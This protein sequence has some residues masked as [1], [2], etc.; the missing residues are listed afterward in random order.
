MIINFLVPYVAFEQS[1]G[2]V[3]IIFHLT[4]QTISDVLWIGKTDFQTF[5]LFQIH[6][7]LLSAF[8]SI[9]SI[10]WVYGFDTNS[11]RNCLY[12][13]NTFSFSSI[14][15]KLILNCFIKTFSKIPLNW[16][17]PE[18]GR[19]IHQEISTKLLQEIFRLFNKEI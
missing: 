3:T 10:L 4:F 19:E 15:L 9:S 5:W 17:R 1:H 11:S 2:I 14:H 12:T 16:T 8:S 18:A 13:F 7:E 6:R